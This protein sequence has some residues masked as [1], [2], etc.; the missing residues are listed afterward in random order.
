MGPCFIIVL[1]PYK[2]VTNKMDGRL[3]IKYGGGGPA[4][5]VS[6]KRG[7]PEDLWAR[8]VEI[9]LQIKTSIVL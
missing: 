9:P 1:R 2:Y 7:V 5:C 6:R 3:C 8:T 4:I